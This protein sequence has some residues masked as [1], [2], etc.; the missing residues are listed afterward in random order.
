MRLDEIAPHSIARTRQDV[1]R[2]ARASPPTPSPTRFVRIRGSRDCSTP[3]PNAGLVSFDDGDHWRSLRQNMPA[4]SVRDLRIKM[5]RC[6]CASSD[7]RHARPRLDSRRRDAAAP[8]GGGESRAREERAVSVQARRRPRPLRRQRTDALAAGTPGRESAPPG[9][10][11]LLPR[12]GRQRSVKLEILD[13]A[14]RCCGP[15]SEH[16]TGL[17]SDPGRTWA[18]TTTLP[19]DADSGY[20]GLPLYWP[21]PQFIISPRRACT[22]VG[23]TKFDPVSPGSDSGGRRSNGG[24]TH[25][26]EYNVPWCRR[27][28]HRRLTV[29][30]ATNAADRGQ[31]RSA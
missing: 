8:G 12:E 1:D 29:D 5:M 3:A 17:Q 10:D 27:A 14:G 22:P 4:I 21:A 28:L 6:R 19:E 7:R 2:D 9:A 15:C 30:G 11:R 31:P 23:I 25:V 18:P 26:S 24:R 13:A 16:R 20:C